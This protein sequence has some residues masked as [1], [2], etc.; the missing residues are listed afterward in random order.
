[1]SR[2]KHCMTFSRDNEF[3]RQS[4]FEYEWRVKKT[5]KPHLKTSHVFNCPQ[6]IG[7]KR[8]HLKPR[9]C[10]FSSTSLEMFE[11]FSSNC[12]IDINSSWRRAF[13]FYEK[14]FIEFLQCKLNWNPHNKKKKRCKSS[15]RNWSRMLDSQ[16]EEGV[17]GE[18]HMSLYWSAYSQYRSV[19]SFLRVVSM[20]RDDSRE[21]QK[22]FKILPFTSIWFWSVSLQV[23]NRHVNFKVNGCRVPNGHKT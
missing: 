18:V 4:Y 17:G 8:Q 22:C 1:M 13:V 12:G 15:K 20:L 10:I 5:N 23:I 14:K 9:W 21:Q 16:G 6:A 7:Q 3:K 11:F 2:P 19:D